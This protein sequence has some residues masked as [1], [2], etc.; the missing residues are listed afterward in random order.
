MKPCHL[1]QHNHKESKKIPDFC[2]SSGWQIIYLVEYTPTHS[3]GVE[4][5]SGKKLEQPVLKSDE[6]A[7]GAEK[8]DMAVSETSSGR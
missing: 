4:F 2:A 8:S 3:H 5:T 1:L 6:T 7:G